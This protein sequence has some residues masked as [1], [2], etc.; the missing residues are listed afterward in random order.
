MGRSDLNSFGFLGLRLSLIGYIAICGLEAEPR[1]RFRRGSLKGA[2]WTALRDDAEGRWRRHA[3]RPVAAL[4]SATHAQADDCATVGG[5][6]VNNVCQV[7]GSSPPVSG[8]LSFD[9]TLRILD[10]GALNVA[11]AGVTITINPGDFLMGPN[12]VITGGAAETCEGQRNGAPITITVNGNVETSAGSTIQSNGCSG[13][14]SIATTGPAD[15]IGGRSSRQRAG[16]A[17]APCSRRARALTLKAA[18]R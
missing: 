15:Q 13:A 3:R 1:P 6:I 17:R 12:S 9:Q 11:A 5:A 18:A 7:A 14:I 8:S 4:A 16:R 2:T 10:G